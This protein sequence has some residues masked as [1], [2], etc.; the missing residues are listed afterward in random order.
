MHITGGTRGGRGAR[1]AHGLG[2]RMAGATARV[3]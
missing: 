3:R 2:N 1:F